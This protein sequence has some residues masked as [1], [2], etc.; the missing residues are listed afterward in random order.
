MGSQD[1]SPPRSRLLGN[2]SGL[3]GQDPRPRIPELILNNVQ[4]LNHHPGFGS[5]P[6]VPVGPAWGLR[7]WL[8]KPIHFIGHVMA[9]G[10]NKLVLRMTGQSAVGRV[11]G[12]ADKIET[13]VAED[14]ATLAKHF[15]LFIVVYLE[16]G[17]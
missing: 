6:L 10:V 9:F 17:E 16:A 5:P 1:K 8:S 2:L 4:V 15:W 11:A 7:Y 13:H 12:I 3:I 14:D